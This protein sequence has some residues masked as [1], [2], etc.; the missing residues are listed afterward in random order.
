MKP[1]TAKLAII[2]LSLLASTHTFA[3]DQGAVCGAMNE[4]VKSY[5][6]EDRGNALGHMYGPITDIFT[7]NT[8]GSDPRG[9]ACGTIAYTTFASS[10]I[11]LRCF[12]TDSQ[13]NGPMSEWPKTK[14][15]CGQSGL[16][17][18]GDTCHVNVEW[19]DCPCTRSSVQLCTDK[20]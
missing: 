19:S 3:F 16:E 10:D 5:A 20:R 11:P 8:A 1:V 17:C 15:V 18:S 13:C 14:R 9:E 4:A 12:G 2:I 6:G 7:R